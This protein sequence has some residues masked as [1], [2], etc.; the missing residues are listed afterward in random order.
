MY[1]IVLQMMIIGTFASA[2]SANT[3]RGIGV[4]TMLVFWRLFLGIGIGGDYPLSAVITSEFASSNR[5]GQMMA[6]VFSMQGIGILLAATVA[7]VTLRCF[8]T[9]IEADPLNLDYV[10]R[11]CLVCGFLT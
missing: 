7:L 9:M 3:V 6:A 11:I 4:I 5:R 8:K 1:G 2:L 10:W